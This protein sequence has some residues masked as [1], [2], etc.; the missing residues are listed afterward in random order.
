MTYDEDLRD[1]SLAAAA[2]LLGCAAASLKPYWPEIETAYIT[3]GGQH[4]VSKGGLRRWQEQRHPEW[5]R[6]AAH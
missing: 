3:P 1:V 4:R 5:S 6:V 2:K